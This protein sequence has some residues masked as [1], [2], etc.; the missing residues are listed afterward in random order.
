MSDDQHNLKVFLNQARERAAIVVT[1]E[2]IGADVKNVIKDLLQIS[3]SFSTLM[4]QNVGQSAD[5]R[6]WR[7]KYDQAKAEAKDISTKLE[8]IKKAVQGLVEEVKVVSAEA[9]TIAKRFEQAPQDPN[10][11]SA[12][13][14]RA[15]AQKMV[16]L[17]V[18]LGN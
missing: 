3:D 6:V 8:G 11:Q 9:V 7:K 14:I 10:L 15:A 16:A 13:R 17:I 12:A 2:H 18:Q 5:V 1:E 4:Q